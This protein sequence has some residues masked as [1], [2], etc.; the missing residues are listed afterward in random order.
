MNLISSR[1]AHEVNVPIELVLSECEIIAL[2]IR[3]SGCRP[4]SMTNVC[5]T[6]NTELGPLEAGLLS[7]G[8][9]VILEGD[10]DSHQSS[11]LFACWVL[12]EAIPRKKR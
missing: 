9:P 11:V 7:A 10:F 2:L 5:L 6:V 8:P 3:R 12:L 1:F 4:F